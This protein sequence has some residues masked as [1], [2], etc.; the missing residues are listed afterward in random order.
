MSLQSIRK[1]AAV[2]LLAGFGFSTPSLAEE[3]GVL[4]VSVGLLN[5]RPQI[6]SPV[7]GASASNET[8][9]VVNFHFYIT[10]RISL[11]TALG[12]TRHTFTAG[13]AELGEASM[14]PLN[15]TAQY[16]FMPPGNRFSPYVGAGVNHTVFSRQRGAVFSGLE[17][18][19]DSNGAIL[20]AGFDYWFNKKYFLNVD[21]RKFYIE[22]DIVPVGGAK[23]E[24]ID[25]D[26]LTIGVAV[27]ARF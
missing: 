25:L 17:T 7:V 6:S 8:I 26:P 10:D 12:V 19:K 14:V 18:F 27:G 15:L 4:G 24:T 22:T 13:G 9:P 1:V 2:S 21:I 11:N 5:I 23:I 16:R 3:G 20:Q